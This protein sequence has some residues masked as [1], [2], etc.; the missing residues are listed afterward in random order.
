[1]K[2]LNDLLAGLKKEVDED[3]IALWAI[4]WIVRHELREES[5]QE[6]RRLSFELIKMMLQ[7]GFRAGDVSENEGFV[8][9]PDPRP[10]S[11]VRRIEHEWDTLGREPNIG[12][13][14]WF[15]FPPAN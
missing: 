5:S 6:V 7:S 8:P 9:W 1:M 12:D 2:S 13:I 3:W 11:V 14:A 4:P 10:E 15:E